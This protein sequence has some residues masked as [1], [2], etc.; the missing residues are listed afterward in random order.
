MSDRKDRITITVDPQL[1]AYAEN[2]VETGQASSVSAVFSEA[3]QEKIH[4]DRR[5]RT[6]WAAAAEKA[7]QARVD[8]MLAH[9]DRQL[10]SR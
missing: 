9:V 6:L 3:L 2:M 4:H 7:D 1:S 5:L 10:A 8:R